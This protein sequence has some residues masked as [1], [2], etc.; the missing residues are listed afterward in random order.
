[1]QSS[2]SSPLSLK[3]KAVNPM[4]HTSVLERKI[5]RMVCELYGLTE[6]E[7]AIMEGKVE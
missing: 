6:D 5:D 2:I 1:M 4:K 3:T 7:I